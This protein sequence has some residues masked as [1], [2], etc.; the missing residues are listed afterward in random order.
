MAFGHKPEKHAEYPPIEE[1]AA[2]Y[3]GSPE[4][5][6]YPGFVPQRYERPTKPVLQDEIGQVPNNVERGT[7]AHGLYGNSDV[8]PKDSEYLDYS[9]THDDIDPTLPE[10]DARE[11]K[12]DPINVRVVDERPNEITR[13]VI[14]QVIVQPGT[15]VPNQPIRLLGQDNKRVRA[16]IGT[17]GTVTGTVVLL[18]DVNQQPAYGWPIPAAVTQPLEV[19]GDQ[20]LW[21][22]GIAAADTASIVVIAER[23]VNADAQHP[24][25]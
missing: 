17:S 12:Y 13:V 3:D 19:R 9:R 11:D 16:L 18:T 23:R 4:T 6:Y 21:V 2:T 14:G 24:S 15:G 20:E 10:Y 5:M 22:S 8:H 25:D 7:E 1:T